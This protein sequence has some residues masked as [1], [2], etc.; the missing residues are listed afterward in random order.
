MDYDIG[1]VEIGAEGDDVA[2]LLAIAGQ[3]VEIGRAGERNRARMRVVRPGKPR[4]LIM[5][6]GRTAVA[7]LA[8]GILLTQRPQKI[9]RPEKLVWPNDT[10]GAFSITDVRVGTNSQ[11]VTN[12]GVPARMFAEDATEVLLGLDTAQTSQDVTLVVTN[13]SGAI[14]TA[15]PALL[16]PAVF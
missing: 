13:N 15:E 9:F 7:A 4:Y 16:G 3:D 8:A 14:V 2:D 6:F 12:A 11:F 1:D 10:A 5:G